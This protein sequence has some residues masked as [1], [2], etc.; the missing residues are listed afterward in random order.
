[1]LRR[2]PKSPVGG[3]RRRAEIFS[4]IAVNSGRWSANRFQKFSFSLGIELETRNT[5][6]GD[7]CAA[8]F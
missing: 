8:G 1:M 7:G 5:D 4:R 3:R 2:R 6:K